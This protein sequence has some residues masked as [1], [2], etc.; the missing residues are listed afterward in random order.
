VLVIGAGLAG[1]AAAYEAARAG[2]QVVLAE[3]GSRPGTKTVSGGLLYTHGLREMFP[4]FWKEDPCPVER[5]IT[6]NVVS[7]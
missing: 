4:E 6:R 1:C 7:S 3:R 2:L 5:A